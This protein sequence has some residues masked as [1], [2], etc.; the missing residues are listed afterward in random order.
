M[1]V[2]HNDAHL[3]RGVAGSTGPA[4]QHVGERSGAMPIQSTGGGG[5]RA[6]AATEAE[7]CDSICGLHQPFP[8]VRTFGIVGQCMKHDMV[9]EPKVS[10]LSPGFRNLLKNYWQ[11]PLCL[12]MRL[13]CAI[14]LRFARRRSLPVACVGLFLPESHV[15]A[16]VTVY[17]DYTSHSHQFGILRQLASA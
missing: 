17:V 15:R 3:C 5:R 11:P 4:S 6:A 7:E 13:S 16:D 12:S 9:S 8:S 1:W 2:R 10:S 14:P